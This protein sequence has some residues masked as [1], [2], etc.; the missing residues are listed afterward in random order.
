M[1]KPLTPPEDGPARERLLQAAIELFTVRGYAATSVREIVEA[2]QLTKPALYYHFGSKEG[3]YLEILADLRRR[4]GELLARLLLEQGSVRSRLEYLFLGLFDEFE[5]QA[6]LVRFLNGLL[7]GPPQGAPPFDV[8]SLHRPLHDAV[9]SLVAEGIAAGELRAFDPEE[10]TV[11]LIALLSFSM[12]LRLC[13]PDWGLGRSGLARLLELAFTG[14]AV[15]AHADQ[16]TT[17]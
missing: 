6:P 5:Q 7:W 9:Q 11:A 3:I 15:P 12:D 16:E 8:E 4:L 2:A 17:R 13:H 1:P 10:I 14:V